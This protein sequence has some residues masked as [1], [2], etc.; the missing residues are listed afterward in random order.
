M[1]PREKG[2]REIQRDDQELR[3]DEEKDTRDK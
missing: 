1:H 3:G 2:G